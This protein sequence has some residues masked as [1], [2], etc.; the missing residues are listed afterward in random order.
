L[1]RPGVTTSFSAEEMLKNN[2]YGLDVNG[3]V[4]KSWGMIDIDGGGSDDGYYTVMVPISGKPDPNMSIWLPGD[5]NASNVRWKD[6]D[7]EIEIDPTGRYYVF[8]VPVSA[9]GNTR[10]NLD[11]PCYY[12]PE[13]PRYAFKNGRKVVYKTVYV[14]TNQPYNFYNV[15]AGFTQKTGNMGFSAKIN[16]TLYAF[17]VDKRIKTKDM[18][19]YG[20]QQGSN[21]LLSFSFKRCDFSTKN[22][23]EFY[24]M[25]NHTLDKEKKGF[26]AWLGRLF[27]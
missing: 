13:T 6:T 20:W 1:G 19:F 8:R 15:R 2:R 24:A 11:M 22:R 26:W 7:I 12:E 3:N 18:K 25:N 10:V 23:H 27:S 4:L 21:K 9:S 17:T 16:D 14:A 5:D